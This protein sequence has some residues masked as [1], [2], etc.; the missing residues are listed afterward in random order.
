MKRVL[1]V[2]GWLFLWL[3]SFWSFLVIT[4]PA[5]AAKGWMTDRLEKRLNAKLSIEELSMRWNFG[6]R[7][8]GISIISGQQSA[9]GS[10]E[11]S[12]LSPQPSAFNVNLASLNI[13]PRL[14]S[15]IRLKPEIAFTGSPSS[16]GSF[17]GSY[18]SEGLSLSFK[19]VLFKDFTI[20]DLPVPSTAM[21]SGTGRFKLVNGRGTIE[22]EVNGIPGGKQRITTPAG[23]G[24]GLDGKLKVTVSMPG[25]NLP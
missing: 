8:K 21:F 25:L 20:S 22:I 1:K 16:G 6:L 9:V 7:L 10:Q 19:D 13:E 11:P 14:L 4:F 3:I 5:E 23:E 24:P 2:I 18:A 17:T 12:A 15:V